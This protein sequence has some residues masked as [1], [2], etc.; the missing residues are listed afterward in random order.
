[1]KERKKGTGKVLGDGYFCEM[2]LASPR[3]LLQT[4]LPLCWI[5]VDVGQVPLLRPVV[6]DP[7]SVPDDLVVTS[8]GSLYP[9]RS[10]LV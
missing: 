1:M 6:Y 3:Q 10:P 5:S 4:Y 9:S 2:A 7:S 8:V